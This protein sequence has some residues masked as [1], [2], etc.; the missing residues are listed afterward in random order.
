MDSINENKQMKSAFSIILESYLSEKTKPFNNQSPIHV[1][2]NRISFDVNGLIAEKHFTTFSVD[3][4]CGKGNWSYIPWIAVLDNRITKSTQNG[5]YVVYLFMENMDG[6]YLTL[7]QGVTEALK[8]GRKKGVETLKKNAEFI[9]AS[10][11]DEKKK[12][13]SENGFKI[14][15]DIDLGKGS[16]G[17]DYQ[18]G[19]ILHKFYGKNDLYTDEI[20]LR[21]LGILL[22]VYNNFQPINKPNYEMN[23]WIFQGNP[24]YFDIMSALRELKE[25]RFTVG[26]FKED[27]K[28]GDNVF[29][30]MSGKSGGIVGTGT[31]ATLPSMM[32]DSINERKFRVDQAKFEGEKLR[33]IINNIT[34]LE[35]SIT[36]EDILQYPELRNLTVIRAPQGTTFRVS[37]EESKKLF[38][39]IDGTIPITPK[40]SNSANQTPFNLSVFI[41]DLSSVNL[42]FSDSFITRFVSSLCTKPFT[43]LTGLSG[44]GKTRLAL[45]FSSWICEEANQMC[46]VPVGA[47]WTNR[48]PLIGYP[49]ALVQSE[50][51]KPETGVIDLLL[52][53]HQNPDKPYF[54]I[55]DEMNLSHVERYFA[56]FLSAMESE[57]PILL[58]PEGENQSTGVPAEIRIPKNLFVIGTV[59]VDETTY[60]FSPKVLDRAFVLEFS[61]SKEDMK[62]FLNNPSKKEISSI[63]GKGAPMSTSFIKYTQSEFSANERSE[64][65]IKILNQFF[66]ELKKL[67]AEF[68]YRTAVEIV[69]FSE[70]IS[71]INK[72]SEYW[73]FN[74]IADAA[75]M[76]K[77]L[78]KVHGSRR[79]LEPVL[80]RLMKLCFYMIPDDIDK[81]YLSDELLDLTTDTDVRFPISLEKIVR[82]IKHL[83]QDGF[84]SFSEA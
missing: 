29:L 82:M 38:E 28:I 70:M 35:K 50:Y 73:D 56:D 32:E 61:V 2:L 75:I 36:R 46:V 78:P 74:H 27:I 34:R 42:R 11:S 58:H 33:V 17:L 12:T 24:K 64:E 16:R 68:G 44:S 39:L 67:G 66:I 20:L 41:Q 59:N 55:L 6:F 77:L 43:I 1:Q 52:R 83:R 18:P 47:D 45:A 72:N 57:R 14:D 22:E 79:K 54:L 23:S 62:D 3:A 53:A 80:I 21:D 31:I 10:I 5:V 9:R 60:M 51:V 4:S 40:P 49:N 15:N 30:W 71:I 13:L 76:L 81:K 48:E 26:S 69:R 19:T 7:N 65:L 25:L 63:S 8:G 84:T 37:E